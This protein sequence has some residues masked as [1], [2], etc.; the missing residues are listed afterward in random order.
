MFKEMDIKN[1]LIGKL[2]SGFAKLFGLV[3]A[4][5]IFPAFSPSSKGGHR[6]L[7]NLTVLSVNQAFPILSQLVNSF[8]TA[9]KTIYSINDFCSLVKNN[10]SAAAEFKEIFDKHGSD[11]A[12]FHNYHLVYSQLVRDRNTITGVLEIGIGTTN[13]N[14]ASHMGKE[15]N[16]GASLRAFKEFFPQSQVYGADV[17]K[18]V[19]FD[20]DRMDAFLVDQT[21]SDTFGELDRSLPEKLD[22]IIDDGLHAPNANIATLNF[23]LPKLKENGGWFI[24]EDI[25]PAARPIW[26]VVAFILPKDKFENYLIIT[27]NAFMFVCQIMLKDQSTP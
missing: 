15:G 6:L 12:L 2:R 5:R 26:E 9:E 22:L 4:P 8:Q 25:P 20:G 3:N 7:S 1:K 10:E 14:I 19:L 16:P 27:R 24:V 11:K 23:A 17:D 13:S 18:G 21:F